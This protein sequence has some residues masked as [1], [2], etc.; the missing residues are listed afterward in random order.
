MRKIVS[1]VMLALILISALTIAYSTH[2]VK[3][4]PGTIIV[5][6]DYP[7]IQE[8]INHANEGDAIYVRSGTYYE[9][10]Y[11]N[12]TLSLVGEDAENTIIDGGGFGPVIYVDAD[13]VVVKGFTIRNATGFPFPFAAGIYLFN[14]L[15]VRNLTIQNNK[16]VNNTNGIFFDYQSTNIT[17]KDNYIANNHNYG[18]S[19]FSSSNAQISGNI[20]INNGY[21]GMYFWNTFNNKLTNNHMNGNKYNFYVGG[22][23]ASNFIHD[24]DSSN[25]V[26]GKPIYYFINHKDVMVDPTTF[27]NIGY[28]G[29][30]NSTNI[31]VQN[32]SLEGLL[33]A[34]TKNSLVKGN[35]ITNSLS[36]IQLEG[37]SN[38]IIDGNDMTNNLM[39]IS[40]RY[41]SNNHV[42]G[43]NMNDNFYG[44]TI[45]S[46]S[47]DNNISR[48]NIAHG[49]IGISLSFSNNN[50]IS[51]N[52]I[53]DNGVGVDIHRSSGNLIFENNLTKNELG[54][55]LFDSLTHN[56]FYHNNFINNA[57]QVYDWYWEEYAPPPETPS[58]N[59][60]DNGYPSGGN[61]WSD[62][63]G[64]DFY[65]GPNQD[66]PGSD[67]IGDTPYVIDENNVDRYPLMQPWRPFREEI[68]AEIV[69]VSLTP[70]GGQVLAGDK[71]EAK[72]T[73]KNIGGKPWTF[74]VGFS[75]QDPNGKWWDAPYKAITLNSNEEGTVTLYWTVPSE[76]PT[77]YYNA[78]V[79]VWGGREDDILMNLLDLRDIE[80]AFSVTSL[81]ELCMKYSKLAMIRAQ[82]YGNF[83]E[84]FECMT[85]ART[86]VTAELFIQSFDHLVNLLEGLT[87][88]GLSDDLSEKVK[89]TIETIIEFKDWLN[90]VE[91]SINTLIQQIA[92]QDPTGYWREILN[93][94]K[95]LQSNCTLE[96]LYWQNEELSG[97]LKALENE[98]MLIGIKDNYLTQWYSYALQ[99]CSSIYGCKYSSLI[100]SFYGYLMNYLIKDG[101]ITSSLIADING[102][103]RLELKVGCDVDIHLY[104]EMGRHT[105]AIY[106]A[107]G[108]VV[109]VENNI[110]NVYYS[111]PFMPSE[112]MIILIGNESRTFNVVII[113]RSE[114]SYNFT[115]G[116]VFYDKRGNLINAWSRQYPISANDR[117][118]LVIKVDGTTHQTEVKLKA[119]I[120]VDPDTLNLNSKGKWITAYIELPR[121]YDVGNIN[122]TTILLNNTIPVD[123][124]AQTEIGDYDG[125]GIMDLMVKFNRTLVSELILSK[126]VKYGNVTLTVS[127]R[128]Y[129][130]TEFMG[131]DTIRVR[132]PGDINMDGKADMKDIAIM[133]KAF[134]ESSGR[135]R[136]NPIADENE[137]GAIDVFDIALVAKNF[138]K[139]YT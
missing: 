26:D 3:A 89:A 67:G 133:A 84:F 129:D 115:F 79:A 60:W 136:W 92:F 127:G 32:L 48:N 135:P 36:G 51:A 69:S 21:C 16:I 139:T 101:N 124:G 28:L 91:E 18:I 4:E 82:V 134:G 87:T 34:F 70:L 19:L 12:K 47:G 29:F 74:Y 83:S 17:I 66:Q 117:Q 90:D 58:I 71:V 88:V 100:S 20:I 109:G 81:K 40:I 61:Y 77:G 105:G 114:A 42:S 31:T 118:T 23:D 43:N 102:L 99:M 14:P 126:G 45:G 75:V 76:A 46:F 68:N 113:D 85:R 8:A 132:M 56:T 112:S 25:T 27:P 37:S 125:D 44:I 131:S 110:P 86:D 78:R 130:G 59:I 11:V 128:L 7:T 9:N 30:V 57:R 123:F 111:G 62:Y 119:D 24:I 1:S 38:N 108:E 96:S 97:A 64:V 50:Y 103:S 65:S 41:S 6:D 55:S 138:G 72:V 63:T 13:N 73:V 98:M 94:L 106:D 93:S 116:M 2:P 80:R 49:K 10:I 5:P 121:G 35:H 53:L 33:L 52:N 39:G 104:D 22:E 107:N 137:D 15:G 54:I 95:N 120:H 122:A